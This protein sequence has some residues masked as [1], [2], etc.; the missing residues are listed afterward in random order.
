MKT[1]APTTTSTMTI[2]LDPPPLAAAA[3][4]RSRRRGVRCA[5]AARG[6][7]RLHRATL[8]SEAARAQS[9]EVQRVKPSDL[10]K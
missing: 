1:I 3:A 7:V 8:P 9:I 4:A 2:Q 5:V 10:Q 6:G